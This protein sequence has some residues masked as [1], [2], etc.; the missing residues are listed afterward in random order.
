M[1][2][3]FLFQKQ[4]LL[5]RMDSTHSFP[6]MEARTLSERET[7]DATLRIQFFISMSGLLLEVNMCTLPD[8]GQNKS[9]LQLRTS[10]GWTRGGGTSL[11]HLVCILT[12]LSRR[13]LLHR[14]VQICTSDFTDADLRSLIAVAGALRRVKGINSPYSKLHCSHFHPCAGYSAGLLVA[15]QDR[16]SCP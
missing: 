13:L 6:S 14:A 1:L 12:H 8:S 2:R 3:D 9:D 16:I 10:F 15:A 5:N 4:E 7:V 11:W